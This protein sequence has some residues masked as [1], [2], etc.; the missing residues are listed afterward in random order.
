MSTRNHTLQFALL[1]AALVQLLPTAADAAKAAKDDDDSKTCEDCP[2]Y[3]GWSGWVEGGLGIQSDDDYHFGRYTG[4]EASGGVLIANGEGRYRGKDGTYADMKAVDLGL[5]SRDLVVGGGKQG[6]YGIE[7]E[8][9]QIPN[10]RRQLSTATDTTSLKTQRDRTGAK[11]SLVPGKAWEVTG[12]YRHETKDGTRDVGATFGFSQTAILPVQFDYQTDDFGVELNY[13]GD[14]LQAQIAYSGSLFKNKQDSI[15]W[16]DPLTMNNG[17]IAEAPDNQS[18]QISGLLGYQMSDHTRIGAK[19]A[20]GRM[21][22][23]QSFLPY[24]VNPAIATPPLPASSLDGKVDTILAK[25]DVDSRPTAKLRLDASYT[26]SNRDNNTPVNTYNYVI[27]DNILASDAYPGFPVA[28]RQ[29]RPYGFEQQLVRT[30]VGYRLPKD[31][32]L[33]AGYDYDQMNRTYQ[34]VE[35]TKDNT[36]WAKLKLRSLDTVEA[37]LKYSYSNRDASTY[38]ATA[39]QN[40]VYPESANPLMK[41]FEMA[42]RQRDKV[43][44][45]FAVNPKENLS[46]GLNVDYYK[47]DYQDMALGL[48]QASGL[49]VSPS[50][51]YVFSEGLSGSAYYTYDK[52]ESDQAGREWITSPPISSLWMESDSNLTQTVGLSLNWKAIPKKLDLGADVV[53][54]DFKGK[55]HY[56]APGTDLPDLTSTMSAI[57]VHGT[58]QMKDNLS[59]RAALWYERYKESDWANANLLSVRG[60]GTSPQNFETYLITLSA[61]YDFK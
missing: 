45:E 59:L 60:L 19:L 42:D 31:A 8:Y 36:L 35:E 32:D 39:Y 4:Y 14:K 15:N 7:L 25:V 10:Y 46:L 56:A 34:Q 12:H 51:T 28:G 20:L 33:S 58:Y 29:N 17:S 44:F 55:I 48:T 5:K 53:Y 52:L 16:T 26:Y 27:T 47:D 43:G 22:Q 37:S 38:M 40:P 13:K 24:T 50:L 23:N 11:F 21:T 54:S 30:K 41:A 2:D 1:M 9:D 61:R 18:H 49:T 57:G 3:S 6:K